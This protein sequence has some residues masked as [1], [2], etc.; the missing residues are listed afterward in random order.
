MHWFAYGID[1]LICFLE[2]RLQ[3]ILIH[4]LPIHGPPP[5]EKSGPLPNLEIRYKLIGYADDLK[6]S[7]TAM[8]EFSLVDRASLLFEKSS[9]CKLNSDP[10]SGK[11][12]KKTFPMPT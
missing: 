6:P 11:C 12:N 9:G 1:P 10:R 2:K 5:D 3:G 7:I 8:H 4:S